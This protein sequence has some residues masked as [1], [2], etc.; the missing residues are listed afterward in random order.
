MPQALQLRRRRAPAFTLVE[1]LVVIA[2]IGL[3]IALLLPAVQAAREAARRM[4]CRNN[5]RQLGIAMHN[6]HDVHKKFQPGYRLKPNSPSDAIGSANPPLLPYLEQGNVQDL[7]DPNLPW[8]MLSPPVV[9]TVVKTFKCPSDTVGDLD[10]YPH[11]AQLG[12]PVGGTFANGSYCVSIGW[13][14][15]L[16]FGA[17][18]SARPV[19][20]K[21]G[22]FAFH[23]RTRLADI[24]DGSSHTF[25]YGEAASGFPLCNGIGCTQPLPGEISKHG[26][27]IEGAAIEPFYGMGLRYSG[28]WGSTI[29]PLNKSPATD[30]FY[31]ISAY[32]DCR[33]SLDGG[34]HWTS[35]FR[36]FH[37][38]GASFLLCD[39]S[40]QFV[41][42]TIDMTIYRGLSTIQGGEVVEIE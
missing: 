26:W 22:V 10:V 15:A 14:D 3:L 35:N 8:Y 32:T 40:V 2:I 36:S 1:L 24:R 20:Q 29:E 30:S 19:T 16:C 5:L 28:G 9:Q 39:G 27:L 6:Y 17:N 12:L 25:A 4:S 42:E 33:S 41:R 21:S 7:I 37:P 38:G 34:P 13:N 18:F 31:D 11:V 23:S